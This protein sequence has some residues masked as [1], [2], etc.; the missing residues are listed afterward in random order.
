MK[1]MFNVK[2]FF[3]KCVEISKKINGFV[4]GDWS[5]ETM[6]PGQGPTQTTPKAII[7]IYDMEN[8]CVYKG[9]LLFSKVDRI[10]SN[11]LILYI[12]RE[13]G[14]DGD[15]QISHIWSGSEYVGRAE[16]YLLYDTV[17]EEITLHDDDSH[18][19]IL[20]K[21]GNVIDSITIH[22]E[23]EVYLGGVMRARFLVM[24]TREMVQML[25]EQY[26]ERR[27]DNDDLTAV[28]HRGGIGAYENSKKHNWGNVSR[29][30]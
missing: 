3:K 24:T 10:D 15:I 17:S 29:V 25:R 7:E 19:N 11:K 27:N 12:G 23:T 1:T 14:S 9:P 20:D 2:E 28:R 5:D 4:D 18:N 13:K 21:E 30:M 6:I 22:N 16:A 26:A 8:R